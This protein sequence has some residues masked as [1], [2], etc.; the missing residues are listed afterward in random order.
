[1]QKSRLA[2]LAVPEP[3][4]W[5]VALESNKPDY[6]IQRWKHSHS[7]LWLT[8]ALINAHGTETDA[9]DL[10]VRLVL[11]FRSTRQPSIPSRSSQSV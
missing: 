3:F 10:I 11:K 7:E 2:K 6:C 1:V 4:D 8:A 9:A 5:I